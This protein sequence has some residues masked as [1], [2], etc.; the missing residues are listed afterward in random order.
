MLLPGLRSL[1]GDF[2]MNLVGLLGF[3]YRVQ[4]S[5]DLKIW[6]DL[7]SFTSIQTSVSVLDTNASLFPNRFYR[8]LQQ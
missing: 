1:T 3:T 6:K 8:A 2:S 5:G 7:Q 4:A